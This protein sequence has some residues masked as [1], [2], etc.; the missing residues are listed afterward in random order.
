LFGGVGIRRGRKHPTRLYSGDVLDWWR[1][2]KIETD[3]VLLLS[4]EMKVPG[5]AW[6]KFEIS[7]KDVSGNVTI[8]QTAIF[9]PKGLFGLIY[10][11]SL[12]LIHLAIFSGML[13]EIGSLAKRDGE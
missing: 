8:T 2:E 11:Y 12:Y 9:D 6:L 7:P 10:W 5:R 13:K 1:V 3:C 4:A